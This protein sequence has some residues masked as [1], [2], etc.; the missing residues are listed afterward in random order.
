MTHNSLDPYDYHEKCGKDAF[1]KLEHIQIHTCWPG[2]GE[3]EEIEDD[4]LVE[5]DEEN[6]DLIETNYCN[7]N[8]EV[9]KIFSRKCVICLERDSIYAFRQCG[10][11][12]ICEQCYQ[13]KVDIDILKCVVCRT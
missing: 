11:Q 2:F 3:H 12:C 4:Y 8:N 1:K 6:E 13:N 9:V 10:H 7:G 5:E